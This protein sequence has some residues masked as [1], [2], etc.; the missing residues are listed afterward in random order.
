MVKE[1]RVVSDEE[2]LIRAIFSLCLIAAP[3]VAVWLIFQRYPIGSWVAQAAWPVANAI[4]ALTVGYLLLADIRFRSRLKRRLERRDT[5]LAQFEQAGLEEFNRCVDNI[6]QLKSVNLKDDDVRR[7]ML[8]GGKFERNAALAALKEAQD[9]WPR[10]NFF[11]V[12]R[13]GSIKRRLFP[14]YKHAPVLLSK[15]NGS[16]TATGVPRGMSQ[17]MFVIIFLVPCA[18]TYTPEWIHWASSLGGLATVE[19]G[20]IVPSMQTLLYLW[21]AVASLLRGK[22]T[23]RSWAVVLPLAAGAT[24]MLLASSVL[25]NLAIEWTGGRGT[26][27][28]PLLPTVFNV[29]ALVIGVREGKAGPAK[30]MPTTSTTGCVFG[31]LIL[32]TAAFGAATATAATSE[33]VPLFMSASHPSQQGFVRIINRSGLSGEVAVSATDDAGRVAGTERFVL[34]AWET[35]HFNSNDLELGNAA[36]GLVGVGAGNGHWRLA[37]ESDLSLEVLAYVRTS[38]G[39]LTSMHDRARKPGLWHLVPTFNPGSNRNQVSKLRIVNTAT[40]E[41]TVGI[42]GVDD[43]GAESEEIGVVLTA[44]VA[45]TLTAQELEAGTGGLTGALGDGS[46]KWQLFVRSDQHILV[47]SLLESETGHLTNLST[48]VDAT[49]YV[50]PSAS[51]PANATGKFALDYAG[52]GVIFPGGIANVNRVFYVWDLHHDGVFAYTADGERWAERD[53]PTVELTLGGFTDDDER[54]YLLDVSNDRVLAYTTGGRR[55]PVVEYDF[56]LR[57]RGVERCIGYANGRFYVAFDDGV[58]VYED[59][60]LVEEAGFDLTVGRDPIDIAAGPNGLLYILGGGAVF[61]YQPSGDPVGDAHFD[62]AADNGDPKGIVYAN[63]RFY[64]ADGDARMVFAYT[65]R[66]QLVE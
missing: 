19:G 3:L 12:W 5:R 40:A 31:A 58:D 53:F 34:A 48:S 37:V 20:W 46:G 23:G 51:P 27:F 61:A 32:G 2:Q 39:F 52:I 14:R 4:A 24:H 10:P 65:A 44:G 8:V 17:G 42:V 62:L 29:I 66:G 21:M 9:A 6:K 1:V 59:G 41:A 11:L 55:T 7:D 49:D 54:L 43:R 35:R 26:G 56:T 13:E 60:E 45:F 47:Q 18:L 30:N 64:V 57:G 22:A 28:L 50:L 15:K 36:K 25:M 16:Q 38:D 63:R 33:V